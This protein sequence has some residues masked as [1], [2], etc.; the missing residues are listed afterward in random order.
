MQES[1][2][3]IK[4]VDNSLE[5]KFDETGHLVFYEKPVIHTQGTKIYDLS[6]KELA[7]SAKLLQDKP[8]LEKK[9]EQNEGKDS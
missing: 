3:K 9:H 7:L 6:T 5:C 8:F 4:T 1:V 2:D